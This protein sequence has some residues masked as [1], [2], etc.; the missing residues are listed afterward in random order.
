MGRGEEV[1]ARRKL[2]QIENDREVSVKSLHMRHPREE[3]TT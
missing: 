3:T 2:A 1:G